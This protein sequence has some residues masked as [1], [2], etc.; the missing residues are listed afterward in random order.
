MDTDLQT[1]LE[2]WLSKGIIYIDNENFFGAL[3]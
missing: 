2:H 3:N 1:T